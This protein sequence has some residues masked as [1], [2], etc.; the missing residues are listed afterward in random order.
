MALL[1]GAAWWHW[2]VWQVAIK[3]LVQNNASVTYD[4]KD[5]T[6]AEGVEGFS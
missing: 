3:I 2:Q 4:Q 1:I 6:V 5:H